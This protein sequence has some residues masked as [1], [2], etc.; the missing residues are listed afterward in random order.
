[1]SSQEIQ[2]TLTAEQ[3]AAGVVISVTLASGPV[4]LRIPP[5]RNGDLI[6]AQV[7]GKE[8]L[9]RILVTGTP[10]GATTTTP[11]AS[12]AAGSPGAPGRSGRTGCLVALGTVAAIAVAFFLVSNGDDT[13]DNKASTAASSSEPPP[14]PGHYSP[15]ATQAPTHMATE[16]TPSRSAAPAP[17]PTTAAP[18]PDPTPTSEAPTPFDRGT[19]LNGEL[20]DSTTA[21]RVTNVDEVPC[22]ASDAH[23][24]VIESIPF[25]SDMD[26][27]NTN[28]K[29]EYAFSYRYTMNG[30]V[31]NEYVYCLVGIGSYSRR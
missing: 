5:T 4:S 21:Q 9:L 10:V 12:A 24:R 8:V 28:T 25:T 3:A 29:T 11:M 14:R 13:S 20:P 17:D 18:V 7:A 27:C 30:S 1:M 23:Y 26:R 31:L 16:S 6:R 19:C 15:P 2:L 22:T